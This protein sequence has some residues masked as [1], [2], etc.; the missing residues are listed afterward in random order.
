MAVSRC[1]GTNHSHH[2]SS[3][4]AEAIQPSI[5]LR[6]GM[7]SGPSLSNLMV[8]VSGSAAATDAIEANPALRSNSS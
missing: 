7:R 6:D 3:L 4:S 2:F 5:V 1:P 8:M